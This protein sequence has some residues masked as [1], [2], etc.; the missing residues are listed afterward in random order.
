MTAVTAQADRV[1]SKM[2]AAAKP[3]TSHQWLFL[4][5]FLVSRLVRRMMLC[6]SCEC[7]RGKRGAGR[8][9]A[10]DR[11]MERLRER[12]GRNGMQTA[13]ALLFNV[14]RFSKGHYYMHGLSIEFRHTKDGRK[15]FGSSTVGAR[16]RQVRECGADRAALRG[17]RIGT[18]FHISSGH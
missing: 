15:L 4:Y 18:C 8:N 1:Q 9:P 6:H 13:D 10:K 12:E 5:I 16:A 14:F 3:V 2:Q 17:H 11:E 7:V